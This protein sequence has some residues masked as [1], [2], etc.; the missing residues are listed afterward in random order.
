MLRYFYANASAM[1]TAMMET[2]A[3]NNLV[4]RIEDDQRCD[5]CVNRADDADDDCCKSV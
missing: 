5:K 2:V 3:T 4:L 1:V